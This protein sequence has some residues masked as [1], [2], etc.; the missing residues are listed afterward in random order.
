MVVAE[1]GEVT[2]GTLV[3]EV[4]GVSALEAR[5]LVQGLEPARLAVSPPARVHAERV[6]VSHLVQKY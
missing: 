2:L 4:S 3:C 5:D 1:E 6:N